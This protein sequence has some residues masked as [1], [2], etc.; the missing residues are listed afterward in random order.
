MKTKLN[1]IFI[2]SIF[3]ILNL[4]I[5][6]K[7]SAMSL[8]IEP[9]KESLGIG[10]QFYIDLIIDSKDQSINTIKGSILFSSNSVSFVRAEEGKSVVDL[11]VEK[12]KLDNDQISFTGII[13]GGF[14]GFIDPFNP[15]DRLPGLVVRLVFEPKKDGIVEFRTSTFSTNLND[16]LGTEVEIPSTSKKVQI[17]NFTRQIKYTNDSDINPELN[18]YVIQDPNIYNNKNVLIFEATDKGTGIK[19]VKIKEGRRDWKEIESP[20]LLIDQ[21]RH[22]SVSL[23][24]TNFSGAS[25]S[26]NIDK[27]PYNWKYIV[28]L[29]LIYVVLIIL[30]VLIIIKIYVKK[31]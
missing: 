23:Q 16:G 6:S 21:S 25:I 17:K 5:V 1:K 7:I 27:V 22:S 14:Q 8:I 18:A 19:N 20:Y 3:I 11:W 4:F 29:G 24:A 28:I 9:S 31:K 30:L 15:K 10:E 2:L 12:P 26:L 13:S